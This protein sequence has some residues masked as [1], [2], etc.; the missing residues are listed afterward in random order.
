MFAA[1]ACT[2]KILAAVVWY[3]GGIILMLKGGSLLSEAAALR[4]GGIG[5][6]VAVACGLVIGGLKAR[7][8]FSR[9][10]RKNLKRIAALE[11]PRLWQ[12]YR[13]PFFLFLATM[14]AL[15]A[16]LSRLAHG[17]YPF[18]IGVGILDLS[19]AAALLGSSIIFWRPR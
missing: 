13:P 10:C 2:L 3:I 6:W 5:P 8:L 16:M 9:L 14:I 4:P 18:L 19:I 11:E 15:G 7:F 17:N 1:S 12:F